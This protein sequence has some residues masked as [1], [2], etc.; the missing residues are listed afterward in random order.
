[1]WAARPNPRL[2]QLTWPR[3][4]PLPGA[5]LWLSA[6]ARLL[7]LP[8]LLRPALNSGPAQPTRAFRCISAVF[9]AGSKSADKPALVTVGGGFAAAAVAV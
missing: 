7:R 6:A 9:A 8:R 3:W 1:M 4:R 5:G 2:I